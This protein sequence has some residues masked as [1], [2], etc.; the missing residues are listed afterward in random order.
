MLQTI[1]PD[2][3]SVLTAVRQADL[4]SSLCTIQK[5]KGSPAHP[6]VTAA[7]QPTGNYED[8]TGMVAIPCM[9][10]PF[11]PGNIQANEIKQLEAILA[12]NIR[13]VL[14]DGYFPSIQSDTDWIAVVD[15]QTF[16]IL[17]AECDSQ[18][19]MTRLRIRT[20]TI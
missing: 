11:S 9:N 5:P 14:L 18:R 12:L 8:V 2:L 13:H 16:D 10:A 3:A 1:T 17:G 4:F 19:V 20:A 15:G 7:G 6:E